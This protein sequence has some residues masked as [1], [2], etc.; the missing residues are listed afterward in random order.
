[1]LRR[2]SRE[3]VLLLMVGARRELLCTTA[4]GPQ[5]HGGR[6]HRYHSKTLQTWIFP[7]HS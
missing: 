2:R 6:K 4:P 5:A 1:M 3:N 7:S